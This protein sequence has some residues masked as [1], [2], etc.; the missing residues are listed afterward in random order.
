MCKIT[1]PD[2]ITDNVKVLISFG[3]YAGGF[4]TSPKFYPKS[5]IQI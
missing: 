2:E 3:T 1:T 5:K 4:M